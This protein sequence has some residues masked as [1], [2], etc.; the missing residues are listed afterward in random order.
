MRRAPGAPYSPAMPSGTCQ[1]SREIIYGESVKVLLLFFLAPISSPGGGGGFTA[2]GAYNPAAAQPAPPPGGGF[3]AEG[4][5]NPLAAPAAAQ[6]APPPAG[7]PAPAGW[8]D[9]AA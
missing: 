9:A 3:T 5:Y 8:W 6:P 1:Y 2:E 7:A 4:A